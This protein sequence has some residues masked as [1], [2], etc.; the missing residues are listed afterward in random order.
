[1]WC[2]SPARSGAGAGALAACCADGRGVAGHLGFVDGGY[3]FG[4]SVAEWV[5]DSLMAL[6]F[7]LVGMEIKRELIHGELDSPKKPRCRSS[8]PALACWR[9]P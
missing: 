1:M 5:N 3:S 4:L 6:F 9:R 2:C 8:P 7:L